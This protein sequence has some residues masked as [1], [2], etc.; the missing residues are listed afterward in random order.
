MENVEIFQDLP[1]NILTLIVTNLKPELYLAKD[2][3]IKAGTQGECMFFL[4][5]GTVAILT[6]TGKEVI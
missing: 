4:S 3:I 2:M 5:S 6:P 1:R